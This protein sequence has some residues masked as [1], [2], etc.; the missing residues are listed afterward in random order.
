MPSAPLIGLHVLLLVAGAFLVGM[1]VFRETH[2][3]VGSGDEDSIQ[4]R[5]VATAASIVLFLLMVLLIVQADLG[6]FSVAKAIR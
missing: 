6:I 2:P 5:R 3:R 4:A 1:R